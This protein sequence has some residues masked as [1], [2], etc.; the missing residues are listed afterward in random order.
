VINGWYRGRPQDWSRR[1]AVKAR[2][3]KNGDWL[4]GTFRSYGDRYSRSDE[5]HLVPVGEYQFKVRKRSPSDQI[6]QRSNWWYAAVGDH[7]LSLLLFGPHSRFGTFHNYLVMMKFR[8]LTPDDAA[9]FRRIRLEALQSFPLSAATH[10]IGG[11]CD[12]AADAL[13]RGSF[14]NGSRAL[15]KLPTLIF[16]LRDPRIRLSSINSHPEPD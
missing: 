14:K 7:Q 4:I 5:E 6:S 13:A 16:V 10:R 11:L 9:D 15:R 2:M 3:V 1:R 12:S 8:K